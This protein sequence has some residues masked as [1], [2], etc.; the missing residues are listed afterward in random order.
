MIR[1]ATRAS[2]WV[3]SLLATT[4]V[5]SASASPASAQSA[6][7]PWGAS[8]IGSLAQSSAA[9]PSCVTTLGP[10]CGPFAVTSSGLDVWGAADELTLAGRSWTGDG[11]FVVRVGSV[12]NTH[13][14]TKAGLMLRETTSVGS[15]HAFL[16]ASP[17]KG[18]AFQRRATTDG[19]SVST[20]GPMTTAPIWLKLERRGTS[21]GAFTSADGATWKAV[22]S[23]SIAFA[24][25][26]TVGLAVSSHDAVLP[27]TATFTDLSL[28]ALLPAPWKSADIGGAREGTAD[29]NGGKFT[30]DASGADIWG[31]SDQFRFTYQPVSGDTDVVTR[32]T[33]VAGAEAWVKAGV[34]IRE[35]LG[36]AAAHASLFVSKGKGIAF[37]RRVQSGVASVSTPGPLATAPGWVKLER[38]GDVI[39]ALW[40]TDGSAW[41]VIGSEVIV[42]PPTFYVG[43][44]M[45]S[46]DAGTL[47]RAVFENVSVGATVA[48]TFNSPPAVSLTAPVPN[49]LLDA[50]AAVTLS[51][52]ATD[53]D[54]TIAGVDFYADATLVGTATA[55]PYTFTWSGAAAGTYQVYAEARDNKGAKARSDARSFTIQAVNAAPSVSLTAPKADATF[56]KPATVTMTADASDSDGTIAAVDFYVGATLVGSDTTAPFSFVWMNGSRGMHQISVVARDNKGATTRSDVR[57]IA[58][59]S[60]N[61]PP[62]VSLTSP[63]AN[64]S[65]G[66]AT[67]V[68][69]AASASDNG[70]SI[71]AVE[72]YVGATL[73]GV[74]TTEPYAVTW[75]GAA[76]GTYQVSAIARDN[77]GA[78]TQSAA[79]A[80][81]VQGSNLPPTVA[82][83]TPVSG[84]SFAG[85]AS[86]T[87]MAAATDADGS[88]AGVD[89]YGDGALLGSSSAS[90]YSFTWNA[91]PAGVHTLWAVARDNGGAV[92][93]SAPVSITLTMPQAPQPATAKVVF[94]PSDDE[95][96]VTTYRV[97]VH[98]AGVPPGAAAPL[99]SRDLG[100]PAPVGG[101]ITVDITTSVAPLP[102]GSYIA[103]VVA[104]GPG[105]ETRSASSPAFTR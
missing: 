26:I 17:G 104:V 10:S 40:S 68:T 69:L 93:T 55:A 28:T 43:L 22:G 50:P 34:M 82:L 91:V 48:P 89:F 57:T 31:M 15:K 5:L 13:A 23:A 103:T 7:S 2:Q 97:D 78:I 38:R 59:A 37:Q 70:G 29:Y 16:L 77:S 60:A 52:D 95:T 12:Q 64:T 44:A 35:S 86:V 39:T 105:G 80:L 96:L 94:A 62:V 72:F 18:V 6:S 67:A 20:S 21:I 30:V 56:Q 99:V 19:L 46:H 81:T 88:I 98:A 92:K 76:A 83:T 45:T 79:T 65:V 27:A 32:V 4:A 54:G 75:S 90:P 14:W 9:I 74:D 58:I 47:G 1:V 51:A 63:A 42:L 41:T 24:S 100:K 84:A 61:V 66:V 101:E 71:E 102:A 33:S 49:A 36:A 25:T 73:V 3:L 53:S 11:V 87:M 8:R 85:P